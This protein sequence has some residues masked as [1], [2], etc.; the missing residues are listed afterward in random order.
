MKKRFNIAFLPKSKSTEFINIAKDFYDFAGSYKINSHSLPHIT[1]CQFMAE[2]DEAKELWLKVCDSPITNSI[3]LTLRDISRVAVDSSNWISIL[4]DNL[5]ALKK[6]HFV[7][8]NLIEGRIGRC[9]EEYDPHM[10]LFNFADENYKDKLEFLK[11]E[12][13]QD[14]FHLV[15]GRSDEVGQFV[16]VVYE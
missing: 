1:L 15:L 11:C 9:F 14:E 16:K 10:T 12:G 2:E 3:S 6:I 8:A 13:I 4:P 7:I 5:E